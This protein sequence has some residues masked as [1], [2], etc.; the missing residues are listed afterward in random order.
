V[1]AQGISGVEIKGLSFGYGAEPV[2]AEIDLT[3]APGEFFAFLGPS[4]SGKSTL[5]RLIAGFGRP[6]QGRIRIGAE[7][8]TDL[9]PWERRVGMVFQ[10]YALWP[11]MTVA[12]NVAFGLEERRLAKAEIAERVAK[13][14]DLIGLGSLAERRPAQLSGGQQQRVALARTLVIE[15]RV[16]LL[17]EPLSNLDAKLRL[18]MRAEILRL[19]RGLGLTTIYVTH[20]QEEA[21][22]T[23]DR[24]ALLDRGRIQQIGSPIALYDRPANRF[25]ATFLGA[26][27]LIEGDVVELHGRATFVGP[28][29]LHIPI[30]SAER[31]PAALALRPQALG[32]DAG[33]S[34]RLSGRIVAREYLGATMRFGVATDLGE[35]IVDVA[36]RPGRAP[37]EIGAAVEL[38]IDPA[39]A[40]LVPGAALSA[41]GR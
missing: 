17:D 12:E 38:G 9:P 19:Q 32:F 8:I 40:A 23:A 39:S 20:D 15:P 4:G 25:V 11:H 22:A 14:L 30:E 7:D 28:G 34:V 5:L 10:S 18:E 41:G 6:D 3:V 29:G 21:N 31:G 2:L 36:H 26:V 16:L 37:L 13:A 33:G 24:I 1:T 27:N 35:L